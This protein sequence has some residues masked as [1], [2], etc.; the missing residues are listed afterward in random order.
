MKWL[1][2]LRGGG[3]PVWTSVALLVA[4][5][6]MAV[7][8][9]CRAPYDPAEQ[10]RSFPNCPPSVL[11]VRSPSE[12]GQSIFFTHPYRLADPAARRYEVVPDVVVPVRLLY[13]GHLFTTPAGEP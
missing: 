2:W 4:F 13:A 9:P 5:Y 6:T 7:F 10:N 8:A 3:V 12:W 11:A 1:A